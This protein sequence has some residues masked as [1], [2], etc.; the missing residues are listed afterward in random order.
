MTYHGFLQGGFDGCTGLSTAEVLD[1]SLPIQNSPFGFQS[2]ASGSGPVSIS[3]RE[4][5]PIA[6]MSTRYRHWH[7]PGNIKYRND[8]N[9]RH[10]QFG[11]ILIPIFRLDLFFNTHLGYPLDFIF[12]FIAT[13]WGAYLRLAEVQWVKNGVP[14]VKPLLGV[15]GWVP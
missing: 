7:F 11:F 5:R 12:V 1:L 4:W 8:L 9:T 10:P 14:G 6:S 13:S 2:S 15:K 3:G